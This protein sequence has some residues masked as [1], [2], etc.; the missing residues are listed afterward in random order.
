MWY[1]YILICSDKKHMKIGVSGKD[2][3]RVIRHHKT[4]NILINSSRFIPLTERRLAL[5]VESYLLRNIPGLRDEVRT[6]DGSTE[7]RD[8]KWAKDIKEI[9]QT[10]KKNPEF[11]YV[12]V[13]RMCYK[14]Y[15]INE[16]I[17][18]FGEFSIIDT[19]KVKKQYES[20]TTPSTGG[21]KKKKWK[22]VEIS[23]KGWHK[24]TVVECLD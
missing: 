15:N 12:D 2:L 14:L 16:L 13:K 10:I 9:L 24:S 1:V 4:Y 20:L 7:L 11:S 23:G 18:K 22:R 5:K 21:V 17:L 19:H 6:E 8:V 3:S